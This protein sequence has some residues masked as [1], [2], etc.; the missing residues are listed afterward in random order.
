MYVTLRS[1]DVPCLTSLV[2]NTVF[3]V[4]NTTSQACVTH[5]GGIHGGHYTVCCDVSEG[6]G[7]A[8]PEWVRCDDEE[9][10]P[11]NSDEVGMGEGYLLFYSRRE[12]DLANV[13]RYQTGNK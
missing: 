2:A 4:E 1:D 8:V 13:A 11:V 7:L 6:K 12:G 5:H 9:V 3:Y 10:Q